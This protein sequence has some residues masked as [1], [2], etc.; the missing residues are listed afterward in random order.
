[1]KYKINFSEKVFQRAS[2]E[3]N[4]IMNDAINRS[5]SARINYIIGTKIQNLRR[6]SSS[7][8]ESLKLKK[9]KQNDENN[10]N[11]VKKTK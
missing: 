3:S 7:S 5:K 6:S 9:R 10:D 4:H 11:A 8:R 2:I 1:M